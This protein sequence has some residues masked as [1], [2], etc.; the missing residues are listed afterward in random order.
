MPSRAANPWKG[1]SMPLSQVDLQKAVSWVNS[2]GHTPCK[3]CGGQ[4]TVD[5]ELVCTPIYDKGAN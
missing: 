4:I 5:D 2:K 3:N 1:T